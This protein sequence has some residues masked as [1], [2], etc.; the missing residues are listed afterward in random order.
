MDTHTTERNQPDHEQ[1]KRTEPAPSTV[2]APS[3]TPNRLWLAIGIT[4]AVVALIFAAAVFAG[5]DEPSTDASRL[6]LAAPADDAIASCIAFSPEELRRVAEV[7]FAG[8]VISVNGPQVV[9]DVDTWYLGDEAS[10][11]SLS[12]PQG[13]EALIGGIPFAVGEQYLVSAANGT[14]N[15]CGF[16]GPATPEYRAAFEQAFATG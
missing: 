4:A 9:M 12:A 5:S 7:A 16:S 2:M 3:E 1:G 6:E 11:V 13:M 10:E 8:T 14:V 15:Y